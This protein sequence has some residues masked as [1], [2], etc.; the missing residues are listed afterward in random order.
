M[1]QKQDQPKTT[2]EM[3]R[4]AGYIS[5]PDA[6]RA[7]GASHVATIHRMISRSKRLEGK[8]VG[9]HWYVKVTS[10]LQVYGDAPGVGE[11]LHKVLKEIGVT[12][13]TNGK[14]KR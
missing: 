1:T 4:D 7:I 5:A 11:N 14:K 6:A 9:A 3:L 10:L 2:E 12:V 13:P 8:R